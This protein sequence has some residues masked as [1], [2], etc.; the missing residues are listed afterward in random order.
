MQA[1]C[2]AGAAHDQVAVVAL[3][4]DDQLQEAER[5]DPTARAR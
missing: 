2:R 3:H 5:G 4:H 1:A